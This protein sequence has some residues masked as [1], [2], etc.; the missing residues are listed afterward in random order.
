MIQ[1]QCPCGEW[2]DMSHSRH[3]HHVSAREPSLDEM[4]AAR[5]AGRE[6]DALN[7]VSDISVVNWSPR[8]PRREKPNE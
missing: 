4:V 3:V 6:Q 1:W 7:M 5:R 2:I 8:F